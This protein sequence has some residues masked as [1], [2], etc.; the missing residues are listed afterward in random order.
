MPRRIEA[1]NPDELM[2]R[3]FDKESGSA[4]I[5]PE[6]LFA[7]NY[8]DVPDELMVIVGE[9]NGLPCDG[10]GVPGEWCQT[11]KIGGCHWMRRVKS[12]RSQRLYPGGPK[13]TLVRLRPK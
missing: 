11:K 12:V 6:E 8:A 9:Q 5:A 4:C 10:G 2:I 1:E 7:E 3:A 13:F